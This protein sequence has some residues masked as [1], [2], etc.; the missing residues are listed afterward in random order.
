ML[1]A[2]DKGGE[3]LVQKPQDLGE[4]SPDTYDYSSQNPKIERVTPYNAL[5]RGFGLGRQTG[6]SDDSYSWAENMDL[7][8]TPLWLK[9]PAI[10]TISPTVKAA[11]TGFMEVA[12]TLWAV[13]GRYAHKH[14]SDVDWDT[15]VKDFG[16]GKSAIDC[17]AFY[18]NGLAK[19]YGYVA[20]G[21]AEPIWRWSSDVGW[22]QHNEA[23]KLYARALRKVGLRLYRANSIN[24]LALVDTDADPFIYAN[25]SAENQHRI[26]DKSSAIT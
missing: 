2:Q 17:E 23:S 11:I 3:L 21:D 24:Q 4:V 9:G 5:F 1:G 6:F 18:S 14:T 26:G 10:T 16:V 25:W 19:A 15:G 7:S 20:M 13:G 12:G 8:C 22:E